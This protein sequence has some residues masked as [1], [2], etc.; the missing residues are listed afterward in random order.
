M[1]QILIILLYVIVYMVPRYLKFFKIMTIYSL[2]NKIYIDKYIKCNLN[3]EIVS[4]H[5]F[6]FLKALKDEFSVPIVHHLKHLSSISFPR[7]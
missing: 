4:S 2:C 5:Y 1:I 7:E 3:Y 6:Q